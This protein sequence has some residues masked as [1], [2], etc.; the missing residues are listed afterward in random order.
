M[1]IWEVTHQWPGIALVITVVALGLLL[2]LIA[3]CIVTTIAANNCWNKRKSKY[4]NG[5]FL[6]FEDKVCKELL[7]EYGPYVGEANMIELAHVS[8][9]NEA[10]K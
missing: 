1:L 7:T 9:L 2:L 4:D 10:K 6:A 5:E 3:G 8:W